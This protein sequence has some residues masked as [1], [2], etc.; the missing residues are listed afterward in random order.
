MKNSKRTDGPDLPAIALI[1]RQLA[2]CSLSCLHKLA[3][4]IAWAARVTDNQLRRAVRDNLQLAY[5]GLDTD[6]R[7][8]LA[9]STLLHVAAALTETA[10]LW[11]RPIDQV[12]ALADES[13]VCSEFRSE[14]GPCI[15]IAPHLGNWEFLNLWLADRLPLMSLYKPAGKPALDSYIRQGRSR[16]GARL[17]PTDTGG[18]R[19]LLKGL[20][21]GESCMILPDQKPG[22]GRG[23]TEARFFGQ[24]VDSSTLV[25]QLI[26]KTGCPVYIAAALRDLERHRFDIVLRPL[27]TERLRLPEPEAANY[28]SRSIELLASEFPEQYQWAYRRF[29]KA[30]YQSLR[31]SRAKGHGH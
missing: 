11:H 22:R 26:R 13:A 14:A 29:R 16:N 31:D 17:L 21:K 20:A 7:K 6:T 24:R 1:N 3:V 5:P 28:L 9:H 10:F 2:R 30:D 27:S 19:G 23:Q 25:Q 12:L 18:L 15:I 4:P 8:R